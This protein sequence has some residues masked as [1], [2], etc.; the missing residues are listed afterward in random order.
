MA[1]AIM[2][3]GFV[4]VLHLFSE[5]IRSLDYSDQYMKAITLA[6][7]KLTELELMD[8]EV[9]TFSGEFPNE[10]THHWEL[11]IMPYDSILNDPLENIQLM[12]VSIKVTWNDLSKERNVELVSIKAKGT[13]YSAADTVIQ[14]TNKGERQKLAPASAQPTPFSGAPTGTSPSASVGAPS[15]N[16]SGA[17]TGGGPQNVS[18]AI[19][20]PGGA[21]PNISGAGG[22]GGIS[23]AP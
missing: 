8:F 4:T 21:Q 1:M 9:D 15:Q 3:V 12:Q 2:G 6:N 17:L 10:E 16:I 11:S 7:N 5:G 23:G 14:G 20:G 13:T 22:A 18:G 19:S